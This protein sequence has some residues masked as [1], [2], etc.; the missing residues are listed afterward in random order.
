MTEW[1]EEEQ[2]DIR[3][4]SGLPIPFVD[5]RVVDFS[6]RKLP[7]DG[8]SVGEVVVRSPWL[9]LGYLKEPDSSEDLW[10]GGYL[11]TGDAGFVDAEGYLQLTDRMKDVIKTGGEWISSLQIE[12]ILTQHPAVSEAA[13]IGVPDETWGERPYALVAIKEEQRGKV[14]G[15][16]LQSLFP[17]VC[18]SWRHF[19][20]GRS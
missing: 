4:R 1:N 5:L 13:A 16:G 12:D 18:R 7:R 10:S 11:H 17:G 14:F 6:G 20:V 15:R 3:C 9:T 2:I 19:E 8:A